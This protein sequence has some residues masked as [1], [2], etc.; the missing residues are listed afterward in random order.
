MDL[1]RILPIDAEYGPRL[2]PKVYR[3]QPPE[4]YRVRRMC[5]H[6]RP[7]VNRLG[8]IRRAPALPRSAELKT[9][10]T[11]LQISPVV[12]GRAGRRAIDWKG[13]IAVRMRRLRH[14]FLGAGR[15]CKIAV[16]SAERR[17][18]RSVPCGCSYPIMAR[19]I[20]FVHLRLPQH[21]SICRRVDIVIAVRCPDHLKDHL[22]YRR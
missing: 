4:M 19:M 8:R 14:E 5:L 13:H 21:D 10:V 2:R 7:R 15:P 16:K 17:P 6:P 18:R 22:V 20:D 12:S 3:A 11:A 1:C 9:A